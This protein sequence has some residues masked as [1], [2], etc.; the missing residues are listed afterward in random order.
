MMQML[1]LAQVGDFWVRRVLFTCYTNIYS[2]L[3][4]ACPPL[5]AGVTRVTS[6][7][8]PYL[9]GEVDDKCT[10]CQV[11][12]EM[13]D[14]GTCCDGHVHAVDSLLLM[15]MSLAWFLSFVS[16]SS[17][18]FSFLPSLP[19]RP[20]ASL[21]PC[22][23]A[24]LLH[25]LIYEAESHCVA[26]AWPLIAILLPVAPDC[27]DD[28]HVP[29]IPGCLV[30]LEDTVPFDQIRCQWSWQGGQFL[31]FGVRAAQVLVTGLVKLHN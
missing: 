26:Q 19:P 5:R 7:W 28:R 9:C 18:F 31:G 20:S 1:W 23:S 10:D 24:S 4:C 30:S 27:W 16:L 3:L 11:T 22:L 12:M 8:D 29:P 15:Y 6:M 17:P 13:G 14:R 2:M 21:P 25:L